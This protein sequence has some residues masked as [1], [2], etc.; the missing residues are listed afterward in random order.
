MAWGLAGGFRGGSVRS[1]VTRRALPSTLILRDFP[2]RGLGPAGSV[3]L[4]TVTRKQALASRRWSPR[5]GV[6]TG[7]GKTA[8]EG[9]HVLDTAALAVP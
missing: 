5:N 4:G 1:V 8:G 2:S 7:S 3:D 9:E 6:P